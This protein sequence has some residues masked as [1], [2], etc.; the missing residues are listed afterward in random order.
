MRGYKRGGE[1][2]HF[3]DRDALRRVINVGDQTP[4]GKYDDTDVEDAVSRR[5]TRIKKERAGEKDRLFDFDTL[6]DPSLVS[7]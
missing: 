2:N 1:G 3:R 6:R 7:G 4:S 5:S